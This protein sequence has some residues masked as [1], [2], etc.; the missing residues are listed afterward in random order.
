[1][2]VISR[3]PGEKLKVGDSIEFTVLSVSGDKVAIGIDAPR[4]ISV[5]RGELAETI[6][7]NIQSS[8][9]SLEGETIRDLAALLKGNKTPAAK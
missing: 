2:L 8:V 4:N 3:K 6:E 5:L 9:Q 1:M 7:S